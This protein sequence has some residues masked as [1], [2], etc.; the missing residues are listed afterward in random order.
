MGAKI[1]VIDDELQIRKLLK[2]TLQAHGFTVI[3]AGT[4]ADGLVSVAMERPDLAVLDLGLPDL[5]GAEVLRQIREWS[6]LP[7]I[8]LTVRDKESETVTILDSGADDYMTKPF[9]MG[10]LVARIRVALRHAAHALTEP[11]LQIGDVQMDLARRVVEKQGQLVRLTPIEYDLLKTL[12]LHAGRVLTHHQL[13]KEVWGEQN[14][15]ATAHYLRVYIGHLRKKLEDDPTRPT[16][17][18]TEPGI[19]YRFKDFQ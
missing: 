10:E 6:Q 7:V 19:G 17:I 5:D 9:A 1:L 8:V 4:G 15:E 13:V 12:V 16:L 14:S 2:V 18:L 3:E 11:V